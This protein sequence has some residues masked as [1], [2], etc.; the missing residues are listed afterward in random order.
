MSIEKITWEAEFHG[1]KVVAT[2]DHLIILESVQ[3]KEEKK[4]CTKVEYRCDLCRE[5]FIKHIQFK[6][7]APTECIC[8][9]YDGKGKS[10][11]GFPC[12]VHARKR[13]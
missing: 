6:P 4:E 12:P 5:T 11:C 1:K 3:P 2:K 7:S 9:E 10:C 8:A 13:K